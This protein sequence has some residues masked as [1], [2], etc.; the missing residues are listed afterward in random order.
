MVRESHT[1]VQWPPHA[2]SHE[3]GMERI[4]VG[5]ELLSY[6]GGSVTQRYMIGHNATSREAL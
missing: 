1:H 3:I 6:V 4:R 2:S 5:I